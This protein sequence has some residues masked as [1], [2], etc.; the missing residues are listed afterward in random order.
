MENKMPRMEAPIPGMGLTSEMGS[1]PWQRPP[2]VSSLDMAVPLYLSALADDDFLHAFIE[3]LEIG[4]PVTTLVDIMVKTAV[5]EGKHT[6][7]VGMLVSPIMVETLINLAERSGIDYVSGLEEQGEREMSPTA[8]RAMLDKAFQNPQ[9]TEEQLEAREE[10]Q[11]AV[12]E[13]PKGL[14]SKRGKE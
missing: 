12:K 5:M 6:I 3:S 13:V 8:L 14:L 9:I 1:R 7:D 11:E 10:M 4:V 2:E